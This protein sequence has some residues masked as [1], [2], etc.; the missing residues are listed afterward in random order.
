MLVLPRSKH[1]ALLYDG[2][3]TEDEPVSQKG[4]ESECAVEVSSCLSLV[5]SGGPSPPS[6][7][8]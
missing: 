7:S 6:G 3:K 8:C 5:F 1:A 4:M 2:K